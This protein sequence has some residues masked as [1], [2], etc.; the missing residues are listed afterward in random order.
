[1]AGAHKKPWFPVKRH[2]YGV[3][4]P[5][6]WEGWLAL[7]LYLA[8]AVG[9]AVLLSPLPTVIVLVMASAAIGYISYVRSDD[10]WRWRGGE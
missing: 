3:G 9:A 6:A 7:C 5:V 2:G 8:T 1:M 10:E 4:F